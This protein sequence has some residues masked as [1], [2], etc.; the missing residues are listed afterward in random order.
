PTE[1]AET[2]WSIHNEQAANLTLYHQANTWY[3]GAKVPGKPRTFMAY[4]GG[5]D[6]Y[7]HICD[8]IAADNY[9]GFVT[10]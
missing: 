8:A 6:V 7:R 3:I 1:K 2:E 10:A 9:Q 4:I 5:V